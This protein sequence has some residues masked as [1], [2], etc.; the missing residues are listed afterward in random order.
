[1]S[2][3]GYGYGF[4]TYYRQPTKAELARKAQA[5][6]ERLRKTGREL[7][8]V[9]VTGTALART[10]WAKAWIANID[11]YADFSN[12]VER[13]KRYV[14]AD[15]VIDLQVSRGHI[16][17]MVQGSH[18][19]PYEVRVAIEPLSQK[20]F[21]ALVEGCSARAQNLEALVAGDFPEE[22]KER[23]TAGEQGLFP[24]PRQIMFGCSCP[25]SARLC[26]HI[27]AAIM[28]VA[29]QLDA[30]PLAL[31]ELRGVDTSELVSR[32]VAQKLDLMLEHADV[33]TPRV[34]DVDDA[35]LTELFGVL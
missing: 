18:R 6:I 27:A 23:L 15:C 20:A 31:F 3:Y 26:K 22:L 35:Q 11:R 19:D 9:H 24:A 2:R 13:G 17:A 32:T 10:W 16:E 8:P 14:R 25:D 33:H 5:S 30:N 1:M 12:R 7:N 29:P 21:S 4:D 28:A 34:M